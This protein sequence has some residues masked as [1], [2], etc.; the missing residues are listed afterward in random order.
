MPPHFGVRNTFRC[1]RVWCVVRI[2]LDVFWLVSSCGFMLRFE[3]ASQSK[4]GARSLL[5]PVFR[6]A[7]SGMLS[8]N[9]EHF[10]A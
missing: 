2:P 4:L 7:D 6:I 10:E 5:P 1:L 3:L 9:V 8:V